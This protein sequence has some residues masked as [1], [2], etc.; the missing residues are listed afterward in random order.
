[1]LEPERRNPE[2]GALARFFYDGVEALH[3]H[4]AMAERIVSPGWSASSTS[5][6]ERSCPAT[7]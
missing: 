6:P 4:S 3:A 1:V 7:V 2:P 5:S